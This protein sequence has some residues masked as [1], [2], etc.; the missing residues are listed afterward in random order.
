MQHR[1][2]VSTVRSHEL[3]AAGDIRRV[4]G[5]MYGDFIQFETVV[6][7]SALPPMRC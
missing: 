4:T 3:Y 2:T 6:D 7:M 1:K 5:I